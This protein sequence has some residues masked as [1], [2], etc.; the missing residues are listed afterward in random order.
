M[1]GNW[2]SGRRKTPTQLKLLR[3]NPGRR[4]LAADTEPAPPAADESFD[5]PPAELDGNK[6]ARAEWERVAPMLRFCGLVSQAE[7]STLTALCL[8]WS[9]YL[10]AQAELRKSRIVKNSE[11][12]ISISPFVAIADKALSNCHW[13]WNE[14]GLTPS[15]RAKVAKLPPASGR[16]PPNATPKSKWGGVL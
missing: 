4:R 1:P 7:R 14:L 6:R 9:A 11:G 10:G 13:L 15:G 5:V 2:N 8:E 12:V 3:G 16:V